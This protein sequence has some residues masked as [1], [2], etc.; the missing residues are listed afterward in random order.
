M[1]KESEVV[2]E[3]KEKEMESGEKG[4]GQTNGTSLKN[5]R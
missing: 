5:P 3:V 1:R 2:N 4:G